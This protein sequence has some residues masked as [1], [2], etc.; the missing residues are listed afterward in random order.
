MIKS[1]FL[2]KKSVLAV[3]L[4]GDRGN[5]LAFSFLAFPFFPYLCRRIFNFEWLYD[6]SK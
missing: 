1:R 3:K 4:F 6:F 2:I 5:L